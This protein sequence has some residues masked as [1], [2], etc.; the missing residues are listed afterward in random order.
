MASQLGFSEF[1]SKDDYKKEL[2]DKNVKK[3]AKIRNRTYKNTNSTKINKKKVENFLKSMDDEE[4]S[5][6]FSE[7]LA[8]FEPPKYPEMTKQPEQKEE[9]VIDNSV[10]PENY[11]N[12]TQHAE[13]YNNYVPYFNNISNNH[14]VH[15][16]RDELMV[17]LNYMIHL[18]E[19]NK[20]EKT[21]TVNEEL[22]LYMFLGVFVIFVVD[23][24]ARVGK[25][26][27]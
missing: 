9:S 23:S 3:R 22:I 6:D 4:D 15:G 1:I 5:T 12:L 7:G 10:S 24:F 14:N 16:S 2:K 11:N 8:N 20:D 13:A 26:H 18:L 21:E 19:E 25:Y 17:K 27:R